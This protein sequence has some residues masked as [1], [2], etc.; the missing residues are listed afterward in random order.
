MP[1]EPVVTGFR[2]PSHDSQQSSVRNGDQQSA[3]RRQ[4]LETHIRRPEMQKPPEGGFC[5]QHTAPIR[6]QS[7]RIAANRTKRRPGFA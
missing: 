2:G 1:P 7:L 5:L 3:N 4:P 6:Y